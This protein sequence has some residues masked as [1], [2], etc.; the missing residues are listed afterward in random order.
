MMKLGDFA[1]V[2]GVTDRQV[3]RL[4]KKYA[5]DLEGLYERKGPNGTWLSEEACE[6]LRGKMKS[7]PVELYDDTKEKKIKELEASKEQ[8]KEENERLRKE[9]DKAVDDLFKAKQ[10]L[11][12]LQDQQRMLPDLQKQVDEKS[13]EIGILEGF[14]KDAKENNEQ[15]QKEARER[16]RKLQDHYNQEVKRLNEELTSERNKKWYQKLLRR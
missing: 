7:Q 14:I 1:R 6:I 16:E 11:L 10:M 3:Q 15:L 4:V 2:Q 9:R 8:L 5:A 12:E 13:K